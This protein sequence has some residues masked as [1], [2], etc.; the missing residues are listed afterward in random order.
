[1]QRLSFIPILLLIALAAFTSTGYALPVFGPQARAESTS[2]KT[3]SPVASPTH[4][5]ITKLKTVFTNGGKKAASPSKFS[6]LIHH[7]IGYGF[8]L[9]KYVTEKGEVPLSKIKMKLEGITDKPQFQKD[10]FLVPTMG[11]AFVDWSLCMIYAAPEGLQKLKQL[12][13]IYEKDDIDK[14]PSFDPG[15]Q[16]IDFFAANVPVKGANNARTIAMH[17]PQIHVAKAG[18][19]GL[20]T[21]CLKPNEKRPRLWGIAEWEKYGVKF[22]PAKLKADSDPGEPTIKSITSPS[23]QTSGLAGS[24]SQHISA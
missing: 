19:I 10:V 12:P 18:E 20:H 14:P 3:S 22:W 13:L 21:H 9:P 24:V 7:T 4:P 17:I 23:T 6:S 16:P 2:T 1:M 15:K 5:M 8:T 11:Y